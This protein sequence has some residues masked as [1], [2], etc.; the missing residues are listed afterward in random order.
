[1]ILVV[2]VNAV[3]PWE[4]MQTLAG[5]SIGGACVHRSV[6]RMEAVRHQPHVQTQWKIYGTCVVLARRAII[7]KVLG[8][9]RPVPGIAL[10]RVRLFICCCSIKGWLLVTELLHVD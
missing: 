9:W 2:H 7:R 5:R 10:T 3:H 4:V 1:V 8:R 6:H